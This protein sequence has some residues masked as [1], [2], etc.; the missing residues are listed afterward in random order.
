M[1]GCDLLLMDHEDAD[2]VD[3]P[4]D[5]EHRKALEARRLARAGKWS[6]AIVRGRDAGGARD[7]L[8]GQPIHCGSTVVLQA[9][10][11]RDDDYG[12]FTVWLPTGVHVRYELEGARIVLYAEVAGV[13]F[14]KPHEEWMRFRWPARAEEPKPRSRWSS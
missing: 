10:E 14:T 6:G 5:P 3:C 9:T 13:S 7:F 1:S 12:S 2:D 8:D 11:S 4:K